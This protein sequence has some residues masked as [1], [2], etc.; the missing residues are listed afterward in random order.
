VNPKS[1]KGKDRS[2]N[3]PSKNTLLIIGVIVAAILLIAIYYYISTHPG[4]TPV[5]NAQWSLDSSGR[6]T[7]PADRGTIEANST[8][9]ESATN[10]T[11]E[12]VVYKSFGDNVYASLCIPKNV[13]KPPV[14][15]VLPAAT[16]TKEI[17]FGM[18]ESLNGMGYASLTL[19]ERGNNGETGSAFMG[20]WTDGFDSYVADG[21]PVQYK[22]IYDALRALDYVKSRSDLDGSNVVI[23]GESIGGM[24][25]IIT[26]AEDSQF[27]GVICVSSSD[28]NFPV[29]DNSTQYNIELNKFLGSIEPSHYLSLLPPRKLVM[30]HFTNDTTIPISDAK[31]LYNKASQPKAFY[32]YNGSWHGLAN[33]TYMP[34]LQRE[35]QGMLGR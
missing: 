23:L 3:T 30:I 16:I 11:R 12:E 4:T 2:K 27:K 29:Y 13:T 10:Y 7:F 6:L 22:Q 31:A 25:S 19:D 15:I 28:F 9:V 1:K 21:T 26:A 35:L 24:W 5:T 14:V 8:V 17:D 34:D 18:A 32:E 33:L 20:N